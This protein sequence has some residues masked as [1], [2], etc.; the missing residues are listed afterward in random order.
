LLTLK[1]TTVLKYWKLDTQK[2]EV[3][4]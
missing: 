1:A 3:F 2:T 4:S